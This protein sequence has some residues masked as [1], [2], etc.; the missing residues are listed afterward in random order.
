LGEEPDSGGFEELCST[1]DV[2]GWN[3]H[4]VQVSFYFPPL[5]PEPGVDNSAGCWMV[6]WMIEF[7]VCY[8]AGGAI[9]RSLV[10]EEFF[11]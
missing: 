1:T 9:Q 11:Y 3:H 10:H 7:A 4:N 2:V 5:S 6:T 8:G